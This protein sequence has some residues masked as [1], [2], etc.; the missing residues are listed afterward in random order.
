MKL[1]RPIIMICSLVLT[2][3]TG[4]AAVLGE[5]LPYRIY[6]AEGE[7]KYYAENE[8]DLLL[9]CSDQSIHVRYGS[10][11]SAEKKINA[12]FEEK[13]AAGEQEC[14]G[15][16]NE[17]IGLWEQQDDAGRE[18]TVP[19]AYERQTTLFT[20]RTDDEVISV[21]MIDYVY[22]GGAHGMHVITGAA[23]NART[24]E[25]LT[26]ADLSDDPEA[27]R[28]HCIEEIIRQ[29][30]GDPDVWEADEETFRGWIEG[31]VDRDSWYLN[32]DEIVFHSM[33][34]ELTPY[35]RGSLEFKLKIDNEK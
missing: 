32:G 7:S 21:K 23:F 29:C 22:T 6:Y 1:L 15:L 33:P 11:S 31:I 8:T 27:F 3:L 14:E 9:T 35:F 25:R 5:E 24:G 34:Y 18:W 19:P 2:I 13:Q 28:N 30:E 17:Q 16:L 12:F 20:G 10:N 26:L 4:T